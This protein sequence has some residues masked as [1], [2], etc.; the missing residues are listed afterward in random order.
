MGE[1]GRTESAE[2]DAGK[3]GVAPWDA[4]SIFRV[5]GTKQNLSP[6]NAA[7][8]WI[9]RLPQVRLGHLGHGRR[10]S[11]AAFGALLLPVDAVSGHD[12]YLCPG[13]ATLDAVTAVVLGRPVTAAA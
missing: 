10:P 3:V 2:A 9:R 4:R 8:D 6:P 13:S 11:S 1:Q 5:V 12:G 7:D